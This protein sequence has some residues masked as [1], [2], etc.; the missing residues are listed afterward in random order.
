MLRIKDFSLGIIGG[1]HVGTID[2]DFAELRNGQHYKIGMTNHLD[3]PCSVD[4]RIDGKH[5][6]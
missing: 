5:Q 1:K 4:V 3:R 2:G 6:G